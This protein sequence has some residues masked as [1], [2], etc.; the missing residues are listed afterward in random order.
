MPLFRQEG[1]AVDDDSKATAQ[2]SVA[3]L[4]TKPLLLNALSSALAVYTVGL[5][6]KAKGRSPA[7]VR[8]FSC[9]VEK[10]VFDAARSVYFT[11]V[12]AAVRASQCIHSPSTKRACCLASFGCKYTTRG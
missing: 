1:E 11:V 6:R 10:R 2:Q 8:S 5:F 7:C 3:L 12:P 4:A 9:L